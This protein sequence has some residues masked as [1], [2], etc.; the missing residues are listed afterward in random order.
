MLELYLLHSSSIFM[1]ALTT[2]DT[3]SVTRRGIRP[4]SLLTRVTAKRSELCSNCG[5]ILLLF[6]LHFPIIGRASFHSVYQVSEEGEP[7]E[8]KEPPDC[9]YGRTR[10]VS[11]FHCNQRLRPISLSAALRNKPDHLTKH[12]QSILKMA[13]PR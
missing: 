7:N 2:K 9:C 11:D 1:R 8:P 5:W 13:L 6:V 12:S 4:F 3:Q 10:L